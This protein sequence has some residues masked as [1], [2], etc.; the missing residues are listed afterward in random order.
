MGIMKLRKTAG[1]QVSLL[2][3]CGL[4][5]IGFDSVFAKDAE[6][7][8]KVYIVPPMCSFSGDTDAAADPL[9]RRSAKD[10]LTEAGVTFVAGT[11][12]IFNQGTS[13]LIVRN[14]KTQLDVVDAFMDSIKGKAEKQLRIKVE[15]FELSQKDFRELMEGD[16]ENKGEKKSSNEGALRDKVREMVKGDKATLIDTAMIVARSG[17]RA[18]VESVIE[19]IYPTKYIRSKPEVID[20]NAKGKKSGDTKENNQGSLL[21]VADVYE[22]RNVGTTLEVDPVL[23]ADERTVDLSL[24]PEIVYLAGHEEHGVYA[25]GESEVV[26]KTP[27]FYTV[28]ATT[29][30]TLIAGEYLMFAVASPINEKSEWV[31]RSRKVMIFVKADLMYVGLPVK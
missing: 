7:Y 21:P 3:I 4:I 17:Q 23:G 22:T 16:N 6:I 13:Q 5:A 1:R 24:S 28:K 26:A 10:I 30:V 12:A 11:S 8:T 15:W 29:Q 14:T 25:E 31:D 9:A 18:K 2:L 19:V 27:I 20:V